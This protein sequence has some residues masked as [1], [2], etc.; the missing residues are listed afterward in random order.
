[1]HH[2]HTSLTTALSVSCLL[3][4]NFTFFPWQTERH[5]I[6]L[7]LAEDRKAYTAHAFSPLLTPGQVLGPGCL[8]KSVSPSPDGTLCP[9]PLSM[10]IAW[11]FTGLVCDVTT[12]V[13]LYA[14]LPCRTKKQCFLSHL[15]SLAL[16]LFT[17]LFFSDPWPLG[18]G[19][20]TYLPFRA[21][22][23]SVSYSPCHVQ[24]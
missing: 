15:L 21:E 19:Y 1:M 2:N 20:T 22:D 17:P 4:Y 6:W 9:P 8:K 14:Q 3:S 7:S 24:L 12:A 11:T 5:M 18:K 10:L 23:L 13:S 16:T